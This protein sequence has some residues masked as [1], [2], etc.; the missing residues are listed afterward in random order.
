M[1]EYN[2]SDY[3][4]FTNGIATVDKFNSNIETGKS[5]IGVAKTTL[6]NDAVFKGPAADSCLEGI[7]AVE[8]K[9]G[10]MTSNFSTIAEFLKTSSVNYQSGDQNASNTVLNIGTDGTTT[11]SN[12]NTGNTNRDYIYNYLI[13]KGY[14]KA[15]ALG[16][17]SNIRSE[18][19]YKPDALGDSGTSYGICQWHNSRWTDLKNYCS[20]NGKDSTTLEG[21]LDFLMYELESKYPKLNNQLKNASNNPEGAYDAAYQMT[22]QFERPAG[23]ET[24]GNNRG[25][26][27]RVQLWEAYRNV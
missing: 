16:I 3:G 2:V 8:G 17:I 9:L 13:S 21:Q 19:S 10:T 1:N 7:A 27:A 25:N 26:H 24:S 12:V 20:Q 14:S 11:M 15:G 6:S 4:I 5:A 22:V 18:S 23:M